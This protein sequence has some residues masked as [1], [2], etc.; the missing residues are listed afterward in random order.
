V[1]TYANHAV[2]CA[3]GPLV[4]QFFSAPRLG[5]PDSSIPC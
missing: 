1:D 2:A 5:S 3:V 4:S